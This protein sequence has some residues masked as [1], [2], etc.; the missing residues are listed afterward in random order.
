MC[1]RDSWVYAKSLS[2]TQALSS[3]MNESILHWKNGFGFQTV[4]FINGFEELIKLAIKVPLYQGK[5]HLIDKIDVKLFF[6]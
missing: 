1:C 3:G 5:T 2:Q 4:Q 6:L